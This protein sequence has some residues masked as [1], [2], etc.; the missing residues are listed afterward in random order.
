MASG[1]EYYYSF[2]Y[3]NIHFVC[4]DSMSSD[5]SPTGAMAT[6]LRND[7][8]A[9]TRPWT[10]SYFHH[11]PYTKGVMD[12]DA[13]PESIEMRSNIVPILEDFGVDLVL[14]GHSHSYERS[15]LIDGHYGFSS[16]FSSSMIKNGGSGHDDQGAAY[17]KSSAGAA[18]H[19]GAVYAVAGN[20]AELLDAPLN[21]P[22]MFISLL[23]LGSMVLDINANRLDAKM[24]NSSGV[25][26]DYFTL[27]KGNGPTDV[28]PTV[29]LI[30]PA[31]NANFTAPASVSLQASAA[32]IDG[33]MAKVE[34]FS[35]ATKLGSVSGSVW[36]C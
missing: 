22:A 30:S 4:L 1:T 18:P 15:Y 11:P 36:S 7:L 17:T 10:I 31:N 9:N 25:T 28:P 3:A 2:D 21:H 12:S 8:G 5:R 29:T 32:D 26:R 23:E 6:W 24:I 19:Q 20:A 34:F 35:G 14:T 13:W 16:S 33:S 27:I